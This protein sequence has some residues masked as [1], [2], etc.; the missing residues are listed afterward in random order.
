MHTFEEAGADI[1]MRASDTKNEIINSLAAGGRSD[2]LRKIAM[3]FAAQHRP[4]D[5]EV[6]DNLPAEIPWRKALAEQY[7]RIDE[8]ETSTSTPKTKS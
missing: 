3:G 7:K 4:I 5:Q 1:A 2:L 8:Q 6:L